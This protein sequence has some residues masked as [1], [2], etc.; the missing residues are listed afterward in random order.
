MIKSF[1]V[2][3][4]LV[5]S[6]ASKAQSWLDVFN[7]YRVAQAADWLAPTKIPRNDLRPFVTLARRQQACSDCRVDSLGDAGRF[8]LAMQ[9]QGTR[10]SVDGIKNNKGETLLTARDMDF[11]RAHAWDGAGKVFIGSTSSSPF[12][13]P[14]S[15]VMALVSQ[16]GVRGH[17]LVVGFKGDESDTLIWGYRL[18][19]ISPSDVKEASVRDGI[20]YYPVVLRFNIYVYEPIDDPS[21]SVYDFNAGRDSTYAQK[22]RVGQNTSAITIKAEF[23]FDQPVLVT[24]NGYQAQGNGRLVDPGRWIDENKID[25]LWVA[26][27]YGSTSSEHPAL[28]PKALNLIEE[29]KW[30]SPDLTKRLTTMVKLKNSHTVF[31]WIDTIDFKNLKNSNTGLKRLILKKI[32]HAFYRNKMSIKVWSESIYIPENDTEP[33][34]L[35]MTFYGNYDQSKV[36]SV[37]EAMNF[38]IHFNEA[39]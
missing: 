7:R 39:Y 21:Y 12:V 38:K 24:Q 30:N 14:Q 32:E 8:A 34:I 27:P 35:R 29:G 1:V 18:L 28:S 5:F 6:F 31:P 2:I 23:T 20:M 36:I 10:K 13:Q 4:F 11:L 3:F 26:T 15:L 33:M 9:G 16:I 17:P 22:T 37:L 19:P 25:H